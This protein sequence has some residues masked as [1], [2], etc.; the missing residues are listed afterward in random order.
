MGAGA[1]AG[2]G[3][4]SRAAPGVPG[5]GC[6]QPAPAVLGPQ[7][8]TSA[9]GFLGARPAWPTGRMDGGRPVTASP[10][11]PEVSPAVGDP[12]SGCTPPDDA[13]PSPAAA[14]GGARLLAPAPATAAAA[15]PRPAAWRSL[16]MLTRTSS[17]PASLPVGPPP[18]L[19]STSRVLRENPPSDASW[20]RAPW[21]G[22]GGMAAGRR[23]LGAVRK[24]AAAAAPRV[25]SRRMAP[26]AT[27]GEGS[28]C[29]PFPPI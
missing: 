27:C 23:P 16:P 18:C 22:S 13:S 15:A 25:W 24:A 17:P 7:G 6:G 14:H 29:A 3:G 9:P 28:C 12:E 11:S 19:P 10:S 1:G 2:G 5:P 26:I 4:S 20:S 21:P 8:V